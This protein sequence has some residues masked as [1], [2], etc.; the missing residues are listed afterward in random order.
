LPNARARERN[1]LLRALPAECYTR[2]APD[3]EIVQ[4]QVRQVL[5][6]PDQAIDHVYFPRD[7]VVTLL[8]P[9]ENG[10]GVESAT[11]G[12]EGMLGVGIALGAVTATE[13]VV[14][15][16]AGEAVQMT[17]FHFRQAFEHTPILH[18][19]V[20]RYTLGL[21]TQFGRTA[22]C[23][24]LHTVRQRCA[25]WLLMSRDRVGRDAFAVT[26]EGLALLLGARR[27]S[28]SEV[29]E[30]LRRN[31]VIEYRRGLV[32]ILDAARLEAIACED[33]AFVRAA[34]EDLQSPD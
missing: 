21:M 6:V 2:L 30:D 22:A 32:T 24:R 7:A 29:A 12:N 25:R 17:Q 8:V 13:E 27:A 1:R 4:L 9:M 28:I 5:S 23:N 18:S 16:I 3:F 14:V 33:Y 31:G 11:V 26:H 34:Y 15:Q 10:T 20:S 19:E